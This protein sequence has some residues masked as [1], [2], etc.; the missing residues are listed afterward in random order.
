MSCARYERWM[1]LEAGGDLDAR[2]RALLE[3]HL[4]VCDLCA[5]SMEELRRSRALL[6]RADRALRREE[7]RQPVPVVELPVPAST[8]TRPFRGL[9]A[10]PVAA[11]LAGAVFVAVL[12][13]VLAPHREQPLRLAVRPLHRVAAPM[14]TGTPATPATRGPGPAHPAAHQPRA[15]R[16]PPAAGRLRI[17]RLAGRRDVETAARV[18]R[19]GGAPTVVKILTDDPSV[20]I[21]CVLDS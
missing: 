11:A 19:K 4:E 18:G 3:A 8:R 5:A 14:A 17:A 2:R 21:L 15:R 9:K 1:A 10:L 20:V 13:V 6:Q 7:A 16:K 12:A